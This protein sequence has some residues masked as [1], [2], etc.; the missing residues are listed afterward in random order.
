MKVIAI[1]GSPNSEG[2][3]A[4]VLSAMAEELKKEGIDTEIVQVGN[5]PIRGCSG[6]GGCFASEGNL[7]IVQDDA[8]NEI[9][10]K[11]VQADGFILGS[12]TYYGGVSGT[13]KCFLDRAF[14]SRGVH[15]RHKSAAAVAVCRRSG[16][17]ET[18]N[19]LLHYLNLSET[20]V[21]P[22]QYWSVCYGMM[23]GEVLQ[24]EEGMQ[25]VRKIASGMAW[26]LKTLEAGKG[27]I[28]PPLLAEQKAFT[29]FVR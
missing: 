18:H 14:F 10:Q 13:M 27:V 25:T 20:I 26:Q 19:Q 7:C 24:D 4:T 22:S 9:T 21:P 2:N 5:Q 6:C 29:N 17:V 15:F 8:V 16:G 11:M 3:T 28:V 1:N 23:P 12:P